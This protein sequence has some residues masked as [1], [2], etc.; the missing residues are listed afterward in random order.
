MYKDMKIELSAESYIDWGDGNYIKQSGTVIGTPKG[1]VKIIS[2]EYP[3][4]IKFINNS[5]KSIKI[6]DGSTLTTLEESCINNTFLESF[7]FYG[8]NNVINLTSTWE[9]CENL[10]NWNMNVSDVIRFNKT[11]KSCK[12]IEYFNNFDSESGT[13]FFETF[14]DCESLICL[15]EINTINETDTHLMFQGTNNLI[16]PTA[17][18][19][20]NILSGYS[21]V[22]L[23]ECPEQHV[24]P[25]GLI[26][27]DSNIPSEFVTVIPPVITTFEELSAGSCE[28]EFSCIAESTYR[29]TADRV[30]DYDWDVIGAEIIRGQ[31]THKI[32]VQTNSDTNVTFN[33]KCTVH[34]TAGT[35]SV[36]SNFTHTRTSI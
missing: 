4:T 8:N 15:N 19:I 2:V 6:N 18:E 35:D 36:N 10:T 17:S 23:N 1:Q 33:V 32:T 5:F 21:W 14:Y 16:N 20:T 7:D 28:Y 31:G 3:T 30:E 34:N 9:N 11:F 12:N 13:D 26:Y 29:I 22:N 25:D 27:D 24:C